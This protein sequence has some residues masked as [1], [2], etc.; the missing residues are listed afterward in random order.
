[1]LETHSLAV[2]TAESAELALEYL[3]DKRP[4]VIFMDHTMQGMDGLQAVAAIKNNP[5]TATIPIMMYTSQKGEVYVGQARA[6]G[7][8]GVLPKEV[9]PVEVSKVLAS[10]RVIEANVE[11]AN[12]ASAMTYPGTDARQSDLDQL[13]QN[14]RLLIQDLF[15][16]QRAIVRR[17]FLDSYESIAARVVDEIR[18]PADV[19]PT[20][21]YPVI[22]RHLPVGFQVAAGMLALLVVIFAS[23]FWQREQ[24]LVVA[25]QENADLVDALQQKNATDAESALAMQQRLD[26]YQQ[27]LGDTYD[28]ALRAIEWG[29]NQSA[30]YQY[31]ELPLGDGRLASF[32]AVLAQLRELGFSG[33]VQID[34]HVGDFCLT[35][36]GTADFVL[37]DAGMPVT[38]CDQP[39]LASAAEVDIGGQQSVAFANFMLSSEQQTSGQIRFN[40][41]SLGSSEPLVDYPMAETDI[42]AGAWNTIAA[43]NHRIQVTLYA[44]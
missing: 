19:S 26:G 1:M 36:A 37:A 25:N 28:S 29:V 44:D 2:D 41:V 17:D 42:S 39:G 31:G 21:P 12:D 35:R 10:L 32:E 24:S 4:D 22:R 15:E 13:D 34:L 8:V 5:D 7:A 11:P 9:E 43:K 14:I 38:L 40:V 18:A 3:S 23:L 27:S 20:R 33:Q 6:L 30:A 16:Q